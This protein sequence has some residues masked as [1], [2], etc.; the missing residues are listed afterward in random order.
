MKQILHIL[1]K[2]LRHHWIE[3]AF[4]LA[5]L[6][7]YSIYAVYDWE[8]DTL[9]FERNFWAIALP[10]LIP[11]TWWFLIARVIQG[12]TLVGDRQF[13][14]TRPYE[15]KKL[16][17]AK[18]IFILLFISLPCYLTGVFLL[19]KAGFNPLHYWI[20]LFW[21]QA[22]L[23]VFPL[24][25]M[26]A[27]AT[28]TRNITQ[29]LVAFLAVILFM[30]GMLA[31]AVI[32]PESS[33]SAGFD[34]DWVEGALV[35]VVSLLVVGLQYVRRKTAL[36]RLLLAGTAAAVA[37]VEFAGPYVVHG[38][39]LL[40]GPPASASLSFRAVLDSRNAQNKTSETQAN[41]D[42]EDPVTIQI[43]II[44]S[45]SSAN[46]VA[47][48]DD[49]RLSLRA[50]D[51]FL[52]DSKTGE[53]RSIMS[54]REE[55][56]ST[57]FE[58]AKGIFERLRG[59][60]VNGRVSLTLSIY[61]IGD[62][63]QIAATAGEFVVPRVG[64]CRIAVR[65]D[66]RV[67]CY[68]ALGS[69]TVLMRVEAATSTC[70]QHSG[71]EPA[72]AG[73][74]AYDWKWASSP[75]LTYGVNPVEKYTFLLSNYPVQAHICPGTPLMVTLPEMT[76]RAQIGFEL[77]DFKVDEYR[78]QKFGGFLRILPAAPRK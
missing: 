3:I 71:D 5:A 68:S 54:A 19:I 30:A 16:L 20:G 44:T 74:V 72:P 21:M 40:A 13:W 34:S 47:R 73:A 17:A 10:I 46:L 65:D 49:V 70:P 36:S 11:L 48:V 31:L 14:I 76:E 24:V 41:E 51:G 56:W 22:Y 38:K 77:S 26:A 2:D 43:P 29:S 78:K 42:V 39:S 52:W 64:L 67:L 45:G 66:D 57:E 53:Y 32:R 7:A 35:V 28:V 55:H 37:L 50:R 8:K 9:V 69:P 4:S 18:A 58:M 61:R 27:L 1:R 33:S 25:P 23:V 60:P 6:S 62:T 63:K 59:V 75:D 12:E 15:W